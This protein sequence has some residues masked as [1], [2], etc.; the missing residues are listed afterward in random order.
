MKIA[1]KDI[2]VYLKANLSTFK[3]LVMRSMMNIYILIAQ[4]EP[5][6]RLVQE[7]DVIP[8]L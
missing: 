7:Q 3:R 8:S 2:L 4:N 5:K 1:F 6:K